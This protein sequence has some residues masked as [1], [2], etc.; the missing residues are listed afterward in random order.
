M[1]KKAL[2][3]TLDK[4]GLDEANDILAEDFPTFWRKANPSEQ[5]QFQNLKASLIQ[6]IEMKDLNA[7]T[8]ENKDTLARLDNITFLIYQLQR[9][10]NLIMLSLASSTL[11]FS[12]A[13]KPKHWVVVGAEGAFACLFAAFAAVGAIPFWAVRAEA[14]TIFS[15]WFSSD[16][17][18]IITSYVAC[19]VS[20]A[21]NLA[22]NVRSGFAVG[23][24]LTVN[25]LDNLKELFSKNNFAEKAALLPTATMAILVSVIY[26][27]VSLEN[28]QHELIA[29]AAGV[30]NGM[31]VCTSKPFFNQVMSGMGRGLQWVGSGIKNGFLYLKNGCK[32]AQSQ[33]TPAEKQ[34]REAQEHRQICQSQISENLA[35]LL[36]KIGGVATH[37]SNKKIA[38]TTA[39]ILQGMR[40]SA[41]SVP[42]FTAVIIDRDSRTLKPIVD[43]NPR[44]R[45]LT[46]SPH[47][48]ETAPLLRGNTSSSMQPTAS[49]PELHQLHDREHEA[50]HTINEIQGATPYYSA[51]SET[52]PTPSTSGTAR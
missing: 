5:E 31:N 2:F 24:E 15:D 19:G 46:N 3:T 21:N 13:A 32:T 14:Q 23:E 36:E 47:M 26:R 45:V 48:G 17:A 9:I 42:E 4:E 44:T 51:G 10:K 12:E 16:Q 50:P 6:S 27:F 28:G 7:P 35:K 29:D 38:Q 40:A 30:S 39:G 41:S 52:P 33:E 22:V 49:S 18:G 11:D 37:L 34:K 8:Q 43:P 25:L 1:L 20:T